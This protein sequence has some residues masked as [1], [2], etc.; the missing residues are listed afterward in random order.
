MDFAAKERF[1]Q[2]LDIAIKKKYGD[3]LD[4]YKANWDQEPPI[5]IIIYFKDAKFAKIT[6]D[7]RGY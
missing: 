2:D 3:R 6:V 5:P 7:P 1:K 4:Y